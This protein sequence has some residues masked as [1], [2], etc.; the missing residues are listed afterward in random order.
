MGQL[1]YLI[2]MVNPVGKAILMI[3]TCWFVLE[4]WSK[5]DYSHFKCRT[6]FYDN[7]VTIVWKNFV[8]KFIEANL[9]FYLS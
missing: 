9:S 2:Q 4:A 6:S 1:V 3:P 7:K 8:G 5:Y